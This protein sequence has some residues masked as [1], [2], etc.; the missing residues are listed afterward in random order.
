M[1]TVSAF[2]K[3]RPL[4]T[5]FLLAYTLTWALVSLI[6]V[7]LVFPV[8]GLFGPALAAIIVTA[9]SEG[10][11]G[12]KALLGRVI[13]WRVGWFWY[14]VTLGL[15]VALTLAMVELHRLLGGA[16]VDGPG[17]PPMLIAM[18]ALLVVGEEIGWRGFALPRLQA[19]FGGLGAS[20]I[21]GTLWAAWHL[22]NATIPG[23]E[24]YWYAFP[25]FALF[26]LTQTILFTWLANHTR[27]SVLLAWL[28][29]GAINVAGSQFAIGDP[30]RQW[31]LSGT[32]FGVIALVVL[33]VLGPNLVRR[34]EVHAGIGVRAPEG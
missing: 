16:M 20:L 22:A 18:L 29:H 15:P 12:V 4:V 11:A 32:V 34:P 19:R 8:L 9:M 7:S 25:A 6:S 3:H 26:V 5:F 33:V 14:V 23:L 27:G 10:A 28:F 31:W 13:Q 17:D 30:V 24:R 2:V 1:Y 21:L